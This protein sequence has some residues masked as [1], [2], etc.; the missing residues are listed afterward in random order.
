[1]VRTST[2][3]EGNF[4]TLDRSVVVSCTSSKSGQAT[5]QSTSHFT[6]GLPRPGEWDRRDPSPL[7]SVDGGRESKKGDGGSGGSSPKGK[8]DLGG[9][10]R[11]CMKNDTQSFV[12]SVR[13]PTTT[14]TEDQE[15]GG[16]CGATTD[17]PTDYGHGQWGRPKVWKKEEEDIPEVPTVA[18]LGSSDHDR[19]TNTVGDDIES[20]SL[21]TLDD[22]LGT[23]ANFIRP[24]APDL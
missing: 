13:W 24:L 2:T 6:K 14:D 12:P 18:L 16:H 9:F 22:G 4:G 7:F 21:Y 5:T 11:C 15:A 8:K 20:L 1:M 10:C 17:C 23:G 3:T 19:T